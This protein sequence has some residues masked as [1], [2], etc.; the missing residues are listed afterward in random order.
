MTA[1]HGAGA[2][3]LDR[4]RA[5]AACLD[6]PPS[7]ERP[8]TLAFLIDLLGWA[9]AIACLAAY[10]LVSAGR[11]SAQGVAFQLGN[12]VGAILLGLNTLWHGALPSVALNVFWAGI[13]AAA[14]L[15][16]LRAR[17]P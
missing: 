6:D 14:L 17:T 3:G 12:L 10:G 7:P 16:I 1:P 5:V 8:V 15:R 2:R 11:L 9:G 13:A 4:R